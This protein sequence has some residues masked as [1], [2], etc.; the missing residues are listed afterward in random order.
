MVESYDRPACFACGYRRLGWVRED[1]TPELRWDRAL[2]LERAHIIARQHGGAFHVSNIVLLCGACHA[3]APVLAS[4]APMLDWMLRREPHEFTTLR[5]FL[6]ELDGCFGSREAWVDTLS[7][8]GEDLLDKL[9]S[10]MNW[11]ALGS[12]GTGFTLS[13]LAY[14]LREAVGRL[15]VSSTRTPTSDISPAH[16]LRVIEHLASKHERSRLSERSVAAMINKPGGRPRVTV[17]REALRTLRASGLSFAAI[18]RKLGIGATTVQRIVAEMPVD[19]AALVDVGIA[20][21]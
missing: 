21:V 15:S 20:D 6:R 18:A 7:P 16:L 19:C 2:G 17:D 10:A 12:H 1:G 3:G 14:G 5:A 8:Y 4:L 13:T 9:D 11:E